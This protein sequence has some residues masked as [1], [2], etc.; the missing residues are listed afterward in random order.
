[1]SRAWS[2][3]WGTTFTH[4]ARH[5]IDLSSS[6]HWHTLYGY[7]GPL[8]DRD[9]G[10]ATPHPSI[11]L[12]LGIIPTEA[13]VTFPFQPGRPCCFPAPVSLR[14]GLSSSFFFATDLFA[15]LDT[16][17]RVCALLPRP[18]RPL[19]PPHWPGQ[20]PL[21]P[22]GQACV[23]DGGRLHRRCL[24]QRACAMGPRTRRR[25]RWSLPVRLA[26]SMGERPPG[27]L[28][29]ARRGALLAAS[30]ESRASWG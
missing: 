29:A 22:G 4:P 21:P 9:R 5:G 19:F 28:A 7:L 2:A 10:D 30:N 11:Q 15:A 6:A 20:R 16:C 23:A 3:N 17:I 18:W 13:S 14:S 27:F 24:C 12:L 26:A 1:M 8:R 25:P